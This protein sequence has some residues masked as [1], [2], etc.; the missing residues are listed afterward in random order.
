MASIIARPRADGS[1]FYS[2]DIRLKRNG[3][4][5]Y[6]ERWTFDRRALAKDW[7]PRRELGEVDPL[8]GR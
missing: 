2:A 5:V 8:S 6:Q 1:K 7:A 3:K 4:L